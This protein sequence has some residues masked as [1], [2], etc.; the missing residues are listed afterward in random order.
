MEKLSDDEKD[1]INLLRNYRRMLPDAKRAFE[2]E[3]M[4]LVYRLMGDE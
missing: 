3:I 1:L 4:D 2:M